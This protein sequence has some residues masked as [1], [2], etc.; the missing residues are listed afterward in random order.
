MHV[1][2]ISIPASEAEIYDAIV[3]QIIAFNPRLARSAFRVGAMAPIPPSWIATELKLA[4]PQRAKL[5]IVIDFALS[6]P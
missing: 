3:P 6:K 5:A 2:Y 1:T 4:N